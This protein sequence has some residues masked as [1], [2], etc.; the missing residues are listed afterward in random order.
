M[1]AFR[2]VLFEVFALPCPVLRNGCLGD[3]AN[4]LLSIVP[5][6]SVLASTAILVNRQ[7]VIR[8]LFSVLSLP[9]QMLGNSFDDALNLSLGSGLLQRRI[10]LEH[11]VY[12][13]S[14]F[15]I[16]DR[17]RQHSSHSYVYKVSFA[18]NFVYNVAHTV[19][20][21][22]TEYVYTDVNNLLTEQSDFRQVLV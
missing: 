15:D 20:I 12:S 1:S 9:I 19:N 14:R 17:F 22:K 3:V 6:E 5:S 10:S 16:A 7:V 4:R 11:L 21:V 18:V 8:L 13:V 2:V